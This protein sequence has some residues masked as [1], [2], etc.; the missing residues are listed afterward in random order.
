MAQV[1]SPQGLLDLLLAAF[2][3]QKPPESITEI[4]GGEDEREIGDVQPAL[5]APAG[6]GIFVQSVERATTKGTPQAVAERAK[7]LGLSWIALLALWQHD[8][9]DKIYTQIEPTIVACRALD[10]GVWLWGWP[11][12][13]PSRID[14]FV[15]FM[16]DLVDRQPVQGLIVN[17]EKPFYGKSQAARDFCSELRARLPE[18]DIGLSSYGPPYFH[19]KFPWS[20]FAP[21]CQF[22]MPQI[23]DSNHDQGP[24]YPTQAM[25]GWRRVGFPTLVPTWGASNAHTAAQMQEM[26]ERTPRAP[27]ACW[28]DMNWLRNSTSRAAVVRQ[29]SWYG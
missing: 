22:G 2:R 5:R 11:H 6:K 25:A 7:D 19:P 14:R 27:A 16:G 24:K 17:A 3:G 21:I 18:T 20:A 26:I 1:Y 13:A 9:R 4:E 10:I 29:M 8:D 12:G 28:W 15:A 23:Y